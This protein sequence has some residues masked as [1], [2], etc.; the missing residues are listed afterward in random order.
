MFL[1]TAK[2][3]GKEY[4]RIV[5]SY[6]DKVSNQVKHKTIASLGS[7]D[8]LINIYPFLDKLIEKYIGSDYTK[9]DNIN[10]NESTILNYGYVVIKDMWDRYKLSDFFKKIIEDK[11]YKFKFDFIKALFSLVINRALKSELS[12]LGYFNQKDYFLILNEELKQHNLYK[13]LDYLSDIKDE[14]E[15]YL[16]NQSINLFNRDISVAL[17]DVTTLYFESKK[18][19]KDILNN[20]GSIKQKGLKQFGLS[21]DYK[22]NEVQI[23]LS[24]LIDKDGIP[25]TFDIYEGNKAETKTLLD[26]IDR[27]KNRFNLEKVTIIADRGISSSLN[28][29]EI[30]QRGYEY[31]VAIK[32]KNKED[33]EDKILNQDD[34]SQI[35]YSEDKGYYGYKE[36]IHTEEK[37]VKFYE[38]Y[39][40]FEKNKDKNLIKTDKNNQQYIN[41]K[42]SLTHKIVSTYSDIRAKKDQSDRNRAIAKLNKKI[43]NNTL[44]SKTNEKYLKKVL[45]DSNGNTNNQNFNDIKDS[46]SANNSNNNT[47][48]K[49]SNNCQIKYEIDLLKIEKEKR[50]DGFYALASSNTDLDSLTIINIHKHIYDIEQGFRELKSDLN[51]R[52]IYHWTYKRIIGHIIISFLAYFLLKNIQYKLNSSTTFKEYLEKENKTLSLKTL[53][54]EINSINIVKTDINNKEYYLKTKYSSLSSKILNTL[55]IKSIDKI[56]NQDQIKEYLQNYK[57]HKNNQTKKQ[58]KK[59]KAIKQE[60]LF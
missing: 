14:L 32:F 60:S 47:N 59:K 29:Y 56:S 57:Y 48:T 38:G 10:N 7:V 2:V 33:L 3:K 39:S 41:K 13:S 18:E 55:K 40:E 52:P 36:F 9:I 45:I 8:K 24:L 54:D 51:I 46:N 42:V 4:I 6:R 31:I 12:K 53:I 37:R 43:Q 1:K 58:T 26:T 17:F 50:Y 11:K 22:I 5:Q 49:N 30:K 25:I 28:L 27:L 16:L 19:D 35:M 34:Y 20:D 44:K 15:D 21:K 23:V